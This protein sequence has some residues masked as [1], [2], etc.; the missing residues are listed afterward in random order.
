MTVSSSPTSI[1]GDS[2]E[3]I[4]NSEPCS[5][6]SPS[7]TTTTCAAATA[8]SSS[9]PS[10]RLLIDTNNN[11]KNNKNDDTPPFYYA[12][13]VHYVETLADKLQHS[14][15][16]AIT[17]HLR[18]SG[19]YWS[20][21]TMFLLCGDDLKTVDENMGLLTSKHEQEQLSIVDWIDTCFDETTGAYG[22]DTGQDGHVLYTL[23]ALQVLAM[24]DCLDR[25]PTDRVVPFLASLQQPDGSFVGDAAAAASSSINTTAA[26]IDTRF[27]Y[28]VLSAL[29]I[30]N[31][32]DAIDI[33]KAVKYI[34]KCFNP[35][36]G[37]YGSCI[38]AESH[39]GQVFCCIG[40]LSIAQALHHYVDD[41]DDD[42]YGTATD[43]LTKLTWWL[44]ERQCD[45]G[46]LNGRSEKQADV[47]YSWWILSSMSLLG[48][49]QYIDSAKLASFIVKAQ[50]PDDGGIADRPDDM[51][52]V[53][54]TFF[55]ISGLSLLGYLPD[56][57]LR[58]DDGN[59]QKVQHRFGQIDPVYALPVSVVKRLGLPAQVLVKSGMDVEERL[60]DYNVVVVEY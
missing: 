54:H 57:Y 42:E 31:R 9:S 25:V 41:L 47:C 3:G 56:T 51:A 14:F 26:E 10:L 52:D 23:S 50:D 11:D 36:D 49:V 12:K 58:D 53:F 43:A 2:N 5:S 37:G 7:T 59:D 55:G 19:V 21:C 39:A 16:G 18:L 48:V 40:A 17:N 4:D 24:A 34:Q 45:S 15:E 8:T 44:S 29:S 30:L 60:K 35:L 6:T 27:S 13:H 22:G 28:C 20:V 1:P 32:L 33:N 46:G 38:G